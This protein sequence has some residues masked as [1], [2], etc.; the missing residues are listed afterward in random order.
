MLYRRGFSIILSTILILIILS[1]IT[2]GIIVY[3]HKVRRS[4]SKNLSV[5]Y[6]VV[7]SIIIAD[8][9]IRCN[10]KSLFKYYIKLLNQSLQREYGLIILDIRSL[11]RENYTQVII[12]YKI[13]NS[14]TTIRIKLTREKLD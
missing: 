7:I 4:L 3:A 5:N 1:L 9:Y 10:N 11:S 2:C 8:E 14:N 12:E 6:S 13:L